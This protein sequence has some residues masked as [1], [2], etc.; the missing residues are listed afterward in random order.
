MD[1]GKILDQWEKS[2]GS[3]KGEEDET[4]P[5]LKRESSYM[6]RQK[7]LERKKLHSMKPQA[8]IDLHG[9]STE[10]AETSL[11]VF[12]RESVRRGLVKVRIIHG[13]GNHTA[14]EPVLPRLVRN[15][16]EKS[17]LCGEFGYAQGSEGGKGAV[18]VALRQRSL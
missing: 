3:Q 9:Q 10:A 4:N 6:Y 5:E 13:K 14:D 2:H 16:I 1:F 11:D 12:I 17:T 15:Y 18:W 7:S 8:E